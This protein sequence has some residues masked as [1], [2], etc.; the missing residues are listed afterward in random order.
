[1]LGVVKFNG[2]SVRGLVSKPLLWD[3]GFARDKRT[4]IPSTIPARVLVRHVIATN[5]RKEIIFRC[6]KG[7]SCSNSLF[8]EL[9]ILAA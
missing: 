3:L 2:S 4:N 6:L 5:S 9:T 1:M 8:T 7:V